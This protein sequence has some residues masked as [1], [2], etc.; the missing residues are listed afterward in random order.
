VVAFGM[1]MPDGSTA[2]R[3]YVWLS[4]WQIE[5][6]NN[7]YLMPIDFETYRKLRNHIWAGCTPQIR[8]DSKQPVWGLGE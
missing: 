4:D 7:N 6:I 5:N 8:S 1:E 2:E 3:N